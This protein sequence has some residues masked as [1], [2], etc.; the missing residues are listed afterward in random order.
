MIKER[1]GNSYSYFFT[2]MLCMMFS[3][4]HLLSFLPAV[5][6]FGNSSSHTLN[7][8]VCDAD[9]RPQSPCVVA[10]MNKFTGTAEVLWRRRNGMAAF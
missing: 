7:L 3:S 4:G 6:S 2:T 8:Y 5:V 10:A 1:K 9:P